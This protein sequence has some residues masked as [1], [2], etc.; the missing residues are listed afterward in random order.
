[1]PLL[2]LD[3]D[4]TDQSMGI[5]WIF[6]LLWQNNKKSAF[7]ALTIWNSG[8]VETIKGVQSYLTVFK[9]NVKELT[10]IVKNVHML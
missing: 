7:E 3:S 9:T 8:W 10:T 1:M 2:W 6:P 4:R 5:L